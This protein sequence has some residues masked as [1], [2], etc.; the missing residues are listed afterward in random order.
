MRRARLYLK[1]LLASEPLEDIVE[2]AVQRY[3]KAASIG[4]REEGVTVMMKIRRYGFFAVAD[5]VED[6][7]KYRAA[8]LE[9]ITVEGLANT[10]TTLLER[11]G[12]TGMEKIQSFKEFSSWYKKTTPLT[13][14][15]AHNS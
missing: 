3:Q 7:L 4:F 2:N 10:P 8:E 13:R 6:A 12:F 11:F 15:K 9:A 14:E 1:R 5:I